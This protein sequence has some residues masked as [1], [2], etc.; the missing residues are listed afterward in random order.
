MRNFSPTSLIS[1]NMHQEAIRSSGGGMPNLSDALRLAELIC[2]R[3][4]HELSGLAGTLA[5]AVDLAIEEAPSAGET[6]D[7][8][9]EAAG[10]LV[11][12]LRLLRAAWGPASGALALADL[13]GLAK[14]L[15]STRKIML[16]VASLP[17]DTVFAPVVAR[18]ALNLLLL[19]AESLPDGGTIRLAGS[20]TDLFV[21]IEGRRAAWPSGLAACLA[22]EAAALAALSD[23]R[24]LQMPLTALLAQGSQ[25]RLSLLIG[26]GPDAGA[27]P[28]RL[29]SQ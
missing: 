3:L 20:A 12:R 4:C 27:A 2:A 10:E 8:A 1:A 29:H 7:L 23:A 14:G 6:L 17:P 28:L 25:L 5:G 15:R 11:A 21:A 26:G 9:G 24:T 19:A 22:D 18:T 16:N 13:L